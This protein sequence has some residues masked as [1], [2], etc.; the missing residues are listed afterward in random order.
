M[1]LMT[2]PI[3]P[4]GFDQAP[5]RA[6]Q[7]EKDQQAG[8]IAPR[9]ARFVEA[10]GDGIEDGAQHQRR[11]AA[12]LFGAEH[13]RQRREARRRLQSGAPARVMGVDPARLRNELQD[14]PQRQHDANQQ[15]AEN[16]VR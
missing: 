11:N 3:E 7:A 13:G 6:E 8:E 16:E 15:H 9:V 4:D 5:E 10:G 2:P 12:P 14:L 1:D